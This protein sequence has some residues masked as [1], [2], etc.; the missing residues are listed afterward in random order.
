MNDSK[1]Y[2]NVKLISIT[3]ESRHEKIRYLPMPIFSL[4]G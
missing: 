2:G 4:F 1:S 3:I